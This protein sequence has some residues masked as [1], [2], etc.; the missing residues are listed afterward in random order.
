MK[1]A[2]FENTVDILVKAYLNDTLAHQKCT[3]CA[4]GNIVANAIG[5]TQLSIPGPEKFNC[6]AYAN[7]A[8]AY[9]AYLFTTDSTG[10]QYFDE[11]Q[12]NNENVLNQ[13]ESTG[14]SID[15]LASIE[16]AFEHGT[17]PENVYEG[18]YTN[19]AWMFNGLM[20]VVDQLAII[21]NINLIQKEAAKKLFV[22]A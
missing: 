11:R 14:Y 12:R 9:W 6:W 18:D 17:R 8:K 13:I 19:D 2:T 1:T 15:Q 10:Q 4:V 20:A 21:H 16:Y 5:T 22:K 3:A 7:G